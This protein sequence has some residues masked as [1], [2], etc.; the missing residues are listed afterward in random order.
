MPETPGEPLPQE[1]AAGTAETPVAVQIGAFTSEENAVALASAAR[2]RTARRVRIAK[3]EDGL[4][5]VLA[6]SFAHRDD[7]AVFGD[8]LGAALDTPAR[9]VPTMA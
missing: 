9:V 7:A 6:G 8:S 1:A 2:E 4:Y 5:R 3:G